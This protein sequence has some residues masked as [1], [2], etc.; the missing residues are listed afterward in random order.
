MNLTIEKIGNLSTVIEFWDC[1][2]E[3][4]YIHKSRVKYCKRCQCHKDDQPNS[5]LDEVIEFYP[6]VMQW[7]W[8][9]VEGNEIETKLYC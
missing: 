7:N 1:E 3:S 9:D 4:D 5:H 2:C 8:T 6:E